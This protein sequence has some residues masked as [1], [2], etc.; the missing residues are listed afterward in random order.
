[1]TK[2]TPENIVHDRRKKVQVTN[3][4]C[5][6]RS[7]WLQF[8][9]QRCIL[10]QRQQ[11]MTASR[12]DCHKSELYLIP[13]S[14]K[15]ACNSIL[16]NDT[17]HF[18]KYRKDHNFVKLG[19]TNT[20]WNRLAIQLKHRGSYL[21]DRDN[22]SVILMFIC[23]RNLKGQAEDGPGYR[24]SF[25][26]CCWS[27]PHRSICRVPHW[28]LGKCQCTEHRRQRSTSFRSLPPCCIHR[29][30]SGSCAHCTDTPSTDL[31][32]SNYCGPLLIS[33]NSMTL[34]KDKWN[35]RLLLTSARLSSHPIPMLP[36]L[37]ISRLQPA[38]VWPSIGKIFHP[39]KCVYNLRSM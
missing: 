18:D 12:K 21:L 36:F 35:L 32:I 38:V 5:C 33:L 11:R 6:C 24:E 39:L 27:K 8:V 34:T 23:S 14:F 16:T 9:V 29:C 15:S 13:F 7:L 3:G 37:S 30:L 2:M 20:S 1:M 10:N 19:F 26:H 25:Q 22:Y 17:M 28:G 4:K 31:G